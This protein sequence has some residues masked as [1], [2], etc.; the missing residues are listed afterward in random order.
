MA[1][2]ADI[3]DLVRGVSYDKSAVRNEPGPDLV[4]VLRA[5][6]IGAG[7]LNRD[8]LVFV[9]SR[10][11]AS[12]Q[13]LRPHDLVIASSSGSRTV[14]GKAASANAEFGDAA[15]GAF[16]A[17]VRPRAPELAG[18]LRNY[19]RTREYRAFVERVA[20]GIN[21]NNLRG[22]DLAGMPICVPPVAEQRRIVAKLDA[23]SDS[24][25]R[26]RADLDRI[27]A[28]AAR[29]KEAVLANA[30]KEAEVEAASI[31]TLGA[32][33]E[34]VRNGL[35]R[36]PEHVPPGFPILK[37]SAIRP[38]TVR[39][40]EVR[41]YVAEPGEDVRRYAL[42][43]GDL[44]FTRFNGNPELVAACGQVEELPDGGMLYPDKLI[45]VRL[46]HSRVAPEFAEIIASSPQARTQLQQ[47][48]KS[49]AGQHGI[50]GGNLKLLR[51]PLPP[52]E[53]QQ[54][55]AR[56][57]RAAL[58][59]IDRLTAEAAAARRLLDRLDQAVLA[60]AFRG[61]LVTQ[62]PTDEPASVLLDRVRAERA[63]TPKAKRG[64][65]VAP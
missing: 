21:I 11:V 49:A 18:W 44:L 34:E 13:L 51:I 45:R 41:Y 10:F 52:I 15:F 43:R 60:K 57:T 40:E 3:F 38:L 35:S 65:K 22:K 7:R 28:L 61:E 39:L 48:I 47:S 58:R 16:C 37:I 46:D 26:A 63:A 9:P 42:R 8:D 4:P 2:G 30:V 31:T 32:L 17:V 29:Y 14:V 62:D 56:R 27:P 36:R 55:I 64:R 19:F 1:T 59:E 20:L 23:L 5:N 25:V 33:A 53:N 54:L 6:N 12:H 50:S 24:A